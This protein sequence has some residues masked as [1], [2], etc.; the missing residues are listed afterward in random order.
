MINEQEIIS[1]EKPKITNREKN[2]NH[3]NILDIKQQYLKEVQFI[4]NDDGGIKKLLYNLEVALIKLKYDKQLQFNEFTQIVT[5]NDE[6]ISDYDLTKIRS[7]VGEKYHIDFS[8]GD[9]LQALKNLSRENS[10]HPVKKMIESKEWDTQERAETLFIDYL[11]ADDND[12]IRTLTKRWLVGAVARIYEPGIKFEVV[13]ILQ[14]RQGIG[15]STIGKKL[16]GQY[17]TDSLKTL[18]KNKDDYQLL[19]GKW[20][21]ELAELSSMNETKIEETKKFISAQTDSIRLPY[22]KITQNFDRTIVFLGTTNQEQ[23]LKDLTGNRRFFPVRLDNSPNKDIHSISNDTIQQ[24]WAEAYHMYQNNERIFYHDTEQIEIDEN[25]R[26]AA[27]EENIL[28]NM[29]DEYLDLEVPK[30]WN[31]LQPYQKRDIFKNG[32]Y[33][34]NGKTMTDFVSYQ[35]VKVSSRE[36]LEVFG[37]DLKSNNINV[38]VKKIN[39]YMN[40]LPNWES[41]KVH[42]GGKTHAGYEKK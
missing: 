33:V 11:G 37:Y 18:G 2:K 13:P 26:S 25:H 20:I 36:M 8:T 40:S 32:S 1:Y 22:D 5:L 15:K 16:A 35:I 12:Y 34:L 29:V 4:E 7:I 14:G 30:E 9:I 42:I 17:F 21:I 28:L 24:I 39:M 38:L 10:F 31:R 6:P 23:Y 41:K 27:V 19:I 3:K